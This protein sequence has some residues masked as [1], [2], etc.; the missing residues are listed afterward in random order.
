M[1]NIMRRTTS[2]FLLIFG[3]EYFTVACFAIYMLLRIA[4]ILSVPVHPTS[5]ELWYYERAVSLASGKGYA[6]YGLPTAYWPVGWPGFLALVFWIF[7][8]SPQ[9]GEWAN[10]ALAACVFFLSLKVATTIFQNKIVG[11]ITVAILT[12]YPNEIGYV[13]DLAT[14]LFYTTLLLLAIYLLLCMKSP[15]GVIVSGFAFGIATLT[16]AQSPFIPVALLAVWW[17]FGDRGRGQTPWSSVLRAVAV[18]AVMSIVVL[19]WTVR[20]YM[21]FHSIVPVSTNGGPTLLGGNNPSARG[22]HT[23]N[24]S[25]M[26]Q[27]QGDGIDEVSRDH[28]AKSL[29]MEWIR[30]NPRA[31]LS[32]IPLKIWRLWAPDGESEWSFQAGFANYDDYWFEF[33]T[34][35]IFNQLYYTAILILFALGSMFLFKGPEKIPAVM[36]TGYVLIG[37]FTLISIVFSGQSRFHFPIMPWVA[38]YAAYGIE[39]LLGSRVGKT[40]TAKIGSAL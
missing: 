30:D 26:R 13:P 31:F 11:R 8:K 2:S 33:R 22:D 28:H 37:Y 34:V 36:L 25:L 19:P 5:D 38:M 16:K 24:D 27:I 15:A 7:G 10:L 12:F 40:A 3:N 20:N 17:W 35:R 21:I 39:R 32:L 9:T 4:L 23:P 1:S 14:E 18:C 29:A 6:Q